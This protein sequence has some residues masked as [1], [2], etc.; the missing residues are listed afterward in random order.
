M[1]LIA[2]DDTGTFAALAFPVP[3]NYL[4]AALE[5]TATG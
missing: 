3:E 5:I 2:I 1:Q 4:G